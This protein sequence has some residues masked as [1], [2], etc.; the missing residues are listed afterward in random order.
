MVKDDVELRR[1]R[2]L[3]WSLTQV[4]QVS[5]HREGHGTS[6]E[7]MGHQTEVALRGLEGHFCGRMCKSACITVTYCDVSQD[8]VPRLSYVQGKQ[9]IHCLSSPIL[10]IFAHRNFH[11]LWVHTYQPEQRNAMQSVL[12][13]WNYMWAIY[14]LRTMTF[15]NLPK[16]DLFPISFIIPF[17]DFRENESYSTQ[18]LT[19]DWKDVLHRAAFGGWLFHLKTHLK[20]CTVMP[21]L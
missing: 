19:V 11:P 14:S 18:P 1:E 6:F 16:N 10:K 7:A 4:A 2:G 5:A 21:E 15:L 9:P 17:P 8:G 20:L 3:Q 12:Y 13:H